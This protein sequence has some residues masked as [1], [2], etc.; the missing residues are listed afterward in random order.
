MDNTTEQPK[1]IFPPFDKPKR[2]IPYPALT[3]GGYVLLALAFVATCDAAGYPA[4]AIDH[5]LDHIAA[6]L[7]VLS[8]LFMLMF[9]MF[10]KHYIDQCSRSVMN[11]LH[12]QVFLTVSVFAVIG[13]VMLE[14]HMVND[15]QNWFF[16]FVEFGIAWSPGYEYR[17]LIAHHQPD[18][19]G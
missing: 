15:V 9:R 14:R 4:D 8:L 17:F 12:F 13:M 2:T 18:A 10:G 16:D 3:I 19:D 1:P 11:K 5:M 6:R 7:F